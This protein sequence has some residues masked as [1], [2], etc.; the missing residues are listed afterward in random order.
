MAKLGGHN[1]NKL[2]GVTQSRLTT[3]D[4][5]LVELAKLIND[6]DPEDWTDLEQS[7]LRDFI[8]AMWIAA[9]VKRL[10]KGY[11]A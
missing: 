3:I 2:G 9:E 10:G 1:L 5:L 11:E 4:D 7:H 8:Q 6:H